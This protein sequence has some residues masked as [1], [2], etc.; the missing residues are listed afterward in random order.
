MVSTSMYNE[1]I[2][3]KHIWS[4][5]YDKHPIPSVTESEQLIDYIV[6][7]INNDQ[8]DFKHHLPTPSS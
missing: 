2:I 6:Q 7:K 4:I 3:S 8:K 5:N 1:I